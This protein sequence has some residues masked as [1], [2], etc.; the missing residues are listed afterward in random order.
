MSLAA[1]A[2]YLLLT[3]PLLLREV[4]SFV[5]TS[6][7]SIQKQGHPSKNIGGRQRYGLA[8]QSGL[9]TTTNSVT[10]STSAE[11]GGFA[12]SIQPL[13]GE[14]EDVWKYLSIAAHET[15]MRVVKSNP[16]LKRYAQDFADD[17][18]GFVA[19]QD[20]GD[21]VK[22]LGAAWVRFWSDENRGY[23]FVRND[24]PELAIGVDLTGKGIGSK[25]LEALID[26]LS[27]RK[28]PA[29]SLSCLDDNPA[30][31]LYKR[32][33]FQPVAGTEVF[34]P[35]GG[36]SFSMILWLPQVRQATEDDL[37]L[38]M[39]FIQKKATFDRDIGSFQGTTSVTEESLKES[40]FGKIAHARV[41]LAEID[42][43]AIGFAL[44]YF[45]FSSFA[46]RPNLWLDDLYVD[47]ESRSCGAGKKLLEELQSIG[48]Q[49]NC[50]HL[51]W[52]ADAENH[53]GLAFY[54]RLGARIT[55][56]NDRSHILR[57]DLN[58]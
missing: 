6:G 45:R 11:G 18:I 53:K 48:R 32:L 58:E 20:D 5:S 54:H 33:R 17:G 37:P 2:A 8:L 46:G 55:E 44:H 9:D 26:E 3:V 42:G 16:D 23:G 13:S 4:H 43:K 24:V 35:I 57:L 21:T 34:N 49:Q 7:M 25:L 22:S 1:S 51:G 47:A 36:K 27:L 28:I 52:T 12:Y 15:D 56:T 30:L 10:S 39:N 31:R 19:L 40:L 50:T 38:I 41:L 14:S 29:L